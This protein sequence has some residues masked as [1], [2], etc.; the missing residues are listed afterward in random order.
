MKQLCKC[1]EIHYHLILIVHRVASNVLCFT[2]KVP[3]SADTKSN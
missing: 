3:E 2:F 1:I